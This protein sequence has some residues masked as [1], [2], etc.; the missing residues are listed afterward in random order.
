M[1]AA[2]ERSSLLT[3]EG[4]HGQNRLV[5]I[6]IVDIVTVLL[7]SGQQWKP[8]SVVLRPLVLPCPHLN[9]PLLNSFKSKFLLMMMMMMT[10]MMTIMMVMMMMSSP[11][12]PQQNPIPQDESD[13]DADV[14]I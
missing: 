10:M 3:R 4:Q 12:W 13:E 1:A 8:G 2:S 9:L 7:F 11:T 6:D 14:Y 5:V